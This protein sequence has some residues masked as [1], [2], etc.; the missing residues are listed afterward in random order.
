M[1]AVGSYLEIFRSTPP[2]MMSSD[3]AK[4][5]LLSYLLVYSFE[6]RHHHMVV[7]P[8]TSATAHEYFWSYS[9]LALRER[10]LWPIDRWSNERIRCSQINKYMLLSIISGRKLWCPRRINGLDQK[11]GMSSIMKYFVSIFREL[12]A[13]WADLSPDRNTFVVSCVLSSGHFIVKDV[14]G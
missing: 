2:L 12:C 13:T 3:I 10:V 7:L 8:P 1:S 14:N 6:L 5:W 9:N 11:L 4:S